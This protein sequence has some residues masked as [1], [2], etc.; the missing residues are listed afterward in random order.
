MELDFEDEEVISTFS[1]EIS[2]KSTL[3]FMDQKWLDQ[4]KSKSSREQVHLF[5]DQRRKRNKYKEKNNLR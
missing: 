4:A 2:N 3:F 1:Y 5:Q